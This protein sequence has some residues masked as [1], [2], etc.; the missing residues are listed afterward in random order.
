[1]E[2]KR[3]IIHGK[4]N[5]NLEDSLIKHG[6]VVDEANPEFVFSLGG[7][8]TMLEAIHKYMHLDDVKFIG[9]NYGKLGFYTD[10]VKDDLDIVDLIINKNYKTEEFRL[11][12]LD[13]NN[14]K[15]YALNEIL[16]INPVHTQNIKVLV[17]NAELETFRGT[18]LVL[19]T[20]S[21]STAFNKSLG[22]SILAPSI[23]GYQLT[24]MASIN[25]RVYKTL[26]S[27]LVLASKNIVSLNFK[28]TDGLQIQV[29]GKVVND[30]EFDN[31]QIK[32]AAKKVKLITKN[33]T[34]FLERVKKSF[35][36]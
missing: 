36:E 31:V 2:A 4:I 19:S 5:K 33:D 21:G 26:S 8:G 34:L 14:S 22:G 6:F 27:P 17:D 10:F 32:M 3:F 11:L 18:G 7:D 25:N 35:L 23:D 13:V 20:P 15:Y 30:N 9:I 29:D 24:E 12:E 16:V 1:M 28:T